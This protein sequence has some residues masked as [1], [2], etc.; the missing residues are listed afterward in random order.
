MA[1]FLGLAPAIIFW[2][3]LV[4]WLAY[5]LSQRSQ[6]SQKADEANLVEWLDEA[7]VFRKSLPELVREYLARHENGQASEGEPEDRAEEILEQ[8]RALADPTRAYQGQLPLFPE[9]Y[10]LEIKFAD[11]R[12]KSI[13]WDSPAPKPRQQSQ[14][15]D[16]GRACGSTLRAMRTR[17][18][19]R[20]T[21]AARSGAI[22]IG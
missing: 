20:K 11:P 1:L 2:A 17:R 4:G 14:S 7:R 22:A 13:A 5:A 9:I 8:L 18:D 16:V 3:V 10:R 6:F 19:T 15:S 21:L 12:I